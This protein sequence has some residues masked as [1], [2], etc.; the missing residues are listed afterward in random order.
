MKFKKITVSLLALL[1]LTATS[2]GQDKTNRKHRFFFYWGYNNATFS[3]TNLHFKG[4]G[5]DFKLKGVKAK[6]RQS[7]FSLRYLR[8]E[9]LT[10][11]Q[12]DYR[13][14]YYLNNNWS[15][16]LGFDHMK[17]VMSSFQ[18]VIIDGEIDAS[19]NAKY[20]GDYDNADFKLDP[21]FLT[22]EHTNGL[23][24]IN[25]H[26]DKAFRLLGDSSQLF[27]LSGLLGVG[28]GVL[29]PKS[30]VRLMHNE[31]NDQ[32]HWAGYGVSTQSSLRL[33][34][35]Q[36]LFLEYNLKGGFIHMPDVLTTAN[37]SDRASHA[38]FFLER[39]MVLGVNFRL[40]KRM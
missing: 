34:F 30:D 6:D 4:D 9:K 25:V 2:F 5:Y 7:D 28:A 22:L 8:P 12:Y 35:K 23:N 26:L 1:I 33:T 3:K 29:V 11:P 37:K 17:Y 31:R 10:I 32:W 15:I 38:F 19:Y 36:I 13:I 18:D 27:Q 14:G 21:D 24:Y 40:G 16:S 39:F 20:A